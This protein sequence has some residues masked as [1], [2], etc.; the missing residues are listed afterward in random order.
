MVLSRLNVVP[1][2]QCHLFDDNFHL[3][4]LFLQD[5]STSEKSRPESPGNLSVNKW[6][7]V[8]CYPRIC[9]STCR[10][11]CLSICPCLSSLLA[12]RN[13]WNSSEGGGAQRIKFM[14]SFTP[15]DNGFEFLW[16]IGIG[17]IVDCETGY[18]RSGEWPYCQVT[19]WWRGKSDK[20][21]FMNEFHSLF[22]Y[23][24]Y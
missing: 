23:D 4:I 2:C 7:H 17:K 18:F 9:L 21:Q 11:V 5:S 15:V 1:P 22:E 12:K 6:H 24:M 16:L 19:G 14:S 13:T 10:P 20:V 3:W 8:Q